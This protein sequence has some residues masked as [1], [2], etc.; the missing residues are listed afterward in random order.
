MNAKLTNII[1]D[2]AKKSIPVGS[3][4]NREPWWNAEIDTAVKERT[5]LKA[6]ANHS[7]EDR[8]A[9]LEKCSAV[10]KLIYDSKRQ[11]WRDFATKL[12]ARSDPSKV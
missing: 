8:K 9:W 2:S 4:R 7:D 11:S 12:N 6:R 1:I 10:K 5:A 3:S